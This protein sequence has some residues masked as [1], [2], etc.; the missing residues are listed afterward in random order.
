MDHYVEV[1]FTGFKKL[2]DALGGVTMTTTQGHQRHQ[3]SHLNLAAGT[4]TPRRRAGPRP[5]PHPAR[6]RRR[7]RPGP[8]PAPAGVPQGAA[9]TRSSSIGAAEQP[10][11]ALR[12]RRHR[13]QGRHH[14]LRPRL[15]RQADG[16]GERASAH[17]VRRH[18]DGRRCRCSYDPATPTGSCRSAPRPRWCG[19]RSSTTSRSRSPPT[20]GR[21]QGTRS[22]PAAWCAQTEAAP[23]RARAQATL[24]RAGRAV[25]AGR[26]PRE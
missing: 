10:Q 24:T 19:P 3:D 20:Q 4:H 23:R 25:H 21:R 2:I 26:R 13:D 11:E 17:Q 8:H 5:G 1:D 14:R 9:S 7:Q 6:R 12:P 16:P 22:T 15:G 18:P